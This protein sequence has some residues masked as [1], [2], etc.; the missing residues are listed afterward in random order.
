MTM[1]YPIVLETEE[2]GAV[3]AYVPGLPVY[4]A[5]DTHAKAER[6]IRGGAQGVPRG[7]PVQ[8]ARGTCTSGALLGRRHWQRRD[9]RGG[10]A[11][12]CQAHPR[13]GAG[14]AREWSTRGAAAKARRRKPGRKKA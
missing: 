13:Q 2:D 14:I 1:L 3:S 4:A 6:A 10:R 9:R 12:R 5:A 11:G 8:Q 7:T